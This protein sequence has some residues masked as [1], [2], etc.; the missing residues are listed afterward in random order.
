MRIFFPLIYDVFALLATHFFQLFLL[1]V[2]LFERER[3]ILEVREPLC[4]VVFLFLL[5]CVF[6]GTNLGSWYLS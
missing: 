1:V 2:L 3:E 4:E 5:L 6:W